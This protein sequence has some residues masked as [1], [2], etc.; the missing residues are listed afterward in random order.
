MKRTKILTAIAIAAAM[1][2]LVGCGNKT[3]GGNSD[4]DV[5]A[6][7]DDKTVTETTEEATTEA[8]T[9]ETTTEA[10]TEAEPESESMTFDDIQDI[11]EPILTGKTDTLDDMVA[12]LSEC[13]LE[14]DDEKDDS[15]DG[16]LFSRTTKYLKTP[17]TF[18][19]TDNLAIEYIS[20]FKHHD[21]APDNVTVNL[22][23]GFTDDTVTNSVIS[24][25]FGNYLLDNGCSHSETD[26]FAFVNDRFPSIIIQTNVKKGIIS[27][28]FEK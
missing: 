5:P 12:T 3:D 21:D 28:S 8:A 1:L 20:I 27:V 11:V 15:F 16:P 26:N 22:N 24:E 14:F 9:A 23:T 2:T 13:G 10:P 19:G 25:T 18:S 17:I 6:N 4:A 7:S